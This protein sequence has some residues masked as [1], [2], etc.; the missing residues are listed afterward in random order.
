MK[1]ARR[2]EGPRPPLV[3]AIALMLTVI[4]ALTAPMAL[5]KY[6]SVG[7]G[8]AKA[9]VA[10]FDPVWEYRH[11]GSLNQKMGESVSSIPNNG[12]GIIMH[13]GNWESEYKIV[14]RLNNDGETTIKGRVI[15]Y[16]NRDEEP[17]SIHT[18]SKLGLYR[19]SV[20]PHV[21]RTPHYYAQGGGAVVASDWW[22][23]LIMADISE[24]QVDINEFEDFTITIKGYGSSFNDDP[25]S[26]AVLAASYVSN[27]APNGRI[28]V[29]G[30]AGVTG[31][32]DF[33]V[34]WVGIGETAPSAAPVPGEIVGQNNQTTH[35]MYWKTYRINF[36][37]IATQV[38]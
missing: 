30:A 6:K 4:A 38:D 1:Q 35:G 5:A 22:P 8:S 7:V 24:K 20:F 34:N 27:F 32:D 36:D 18:D 12:A 33:H 23:M 13:P 16:N 29:R 37:G 17:L 26:A 21:S 14:W 31:A 9:R 28:N 15:P 19:S 3:G 11:S 25:A 10:I 2:Q